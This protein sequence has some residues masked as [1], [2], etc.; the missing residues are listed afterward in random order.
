MPV[1]VQPP[2]SSTH[3]QPQDVQAGPLLYDMNAADGHFS[4][5]SNDALKTVSTFA[6]IVDL[7][8]WKEDYYV[9][10]YIVCVCAHVLTCTALLSLYLCVV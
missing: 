1:T 8:D 6:L 5:K 7:L 9:V 10:L 2:S 3:P 4:A